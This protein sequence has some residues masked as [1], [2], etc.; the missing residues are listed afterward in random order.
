[1]H[2]D[3]FQEEFLGSLSNDEDSELEISEDDDDG[4]WQDSDQESDAVE[5]GMGDSLNHDGSIN[6]SEASD[7]AMVDDSGDNQNTNERFKWTKQ[8]PEEPSFV[9]Q[10]PEFQTPEQKYTLPLDETC[11][12]F[13]VLLQFLDADI[14]DSIVLESNRYA[15]SIQERNP[16]ALPGFT[17][18]TVTELWSFLGLQILTGM[19]KKPAIS[20]Y[21]STNALI[22]T[23]FFSRTMS[24]NRYV[25]GVA[26][27]SFNY[28]RNFV[29][30]SMQ[31]QRHSPFSAF[32]QQRRNAG[33]N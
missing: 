27:H 22:N 18:I 31:I 25:Y 6:D 23:P 17:P 29:M 15:D 3:H 14:I 8:D 24:R 16:S 30:L 11:T 12:P 20:D 19:V 5:D 4:S 28:S 13:D 9:P 33:P 10:V 2:A 26:A 7:N 32:L 1:M 21:W